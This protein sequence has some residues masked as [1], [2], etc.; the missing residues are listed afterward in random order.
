ME[1]AE[2][3]THGPSAGDGPDLL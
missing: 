1:L 2:R 3:G